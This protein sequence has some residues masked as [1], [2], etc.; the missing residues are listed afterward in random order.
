MQFRSWKRGGGAI[1]TCWAST[2]QTTAGDSAV[3][4]CAVD[5]ILE[6]TALCRF[7]IQVP[8][9]WI[10]SSLGLLDFT[11]C[12]Y[13]LFQGGFLL[14]SGVRSFPSNR[15]LI[16]RNVQVARHC[17]CVAGTAASRSTHCACLGA[18][19]RGGLRPAGSGAAALDRMAEFIPVPDG[20]LLID[21]D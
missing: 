4:W 11:D 17:S 16:L 10:R 15:Y 7:P 8:E 19:H 2:L 12:F 9:G 1:S 21:K 6:V 13:Y 5:C 18:C 3:C 20:F 14:W